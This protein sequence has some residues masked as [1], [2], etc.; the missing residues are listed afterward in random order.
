MTD[1]IHAEVR[2]AIAVAMVALAPDVVR[3]TYTIGEDWHG[4]PAI[5]FRMVLADQAT[6][7]ARLLQSINRVQDRL[8]GELQPYEK[9][10]LWPYFN[11]RSQS[12]Q[13]RMRCKEWE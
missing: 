6:E 7:G 13:N 11:C 8:Q 10:G 9:W 5:Y 1:E 3:V 12:E 4:D 2:R